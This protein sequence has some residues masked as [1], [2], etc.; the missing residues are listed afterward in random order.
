MLTLCYG[1]PAVSH[2]F[3]NSDGG[4]DPVKGLIDQYSGLVSRLGFSGIM[5]VC[6][7]LAFKRVSRQAAVAV[8]AVFAGLQALAYAGYIKVDYQ[9]VSDDAQRAMDVTG[10]GKFDK[11]DVKVIWS[12]LYDMLA[13]Q[14][15]NSAGFASGFALGFYKL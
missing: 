13:Y 2:A 7:A 8:G 5:G 1:L 6:T 15:P 3:N 9:K 4:S 11:E 14:L 10:D 12:R